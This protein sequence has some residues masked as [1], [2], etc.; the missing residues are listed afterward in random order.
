MNATRRQFLSAAVG[1]SAIVSLSPV[2]PNFLLQAAA[3]EGSSKGNTVLV[4][5]QLSGGNDGLNT[6]VPY[7]DDAYY[8]NRFTLAI[9]K[10]A[11]RKI[12]DHVG[13]HPSMSGF[14]DLLEAGSLS[15][16]QGVGYPNPNRSHFE[17]MDLWHTAHRQADRRQV[18]WL[19]NSLDKFAN[20]GRDVPAMHFGS[21]KQPLAL[22]AEKVRVPSIRSLKR[23]RLEGSKDVQLFQTIKTV[24]EADRSSQDDLLGFIQRSTVAAISTS[25]RVEQALGN[26]KSDVEYP[27]TRLAQKLKTVA[28]LIDA[29]MS[30]RVYYLTLGGFDTHANQAQAH[31]G[32]LN[33]LSGAIRSFVQDVDAHGHGE[34]VMVMTFSEFG[35]R[36]KENASR[37]TDHGAASQMFLAGNKVKPGLV[38]KHPSLTDLEDGDPKFHTDYRQVYATV[39]EDWLGWK[40]EA[41]LGK[42]FAKLPVIA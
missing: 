25:Q 24:T 20:L 42:R 12:D 35:R 27:G 21:E 13:L 32:L 36:L 34:R 30:T 10:N 2:V 31:A 15:I 16:I 18:G 28:Q 11:V 8:K 26:Y 22:A 37:G 19:G 5:V 1:S 14:S 3:R 29:G 23:F 40:S 33:E 7:G 4:V 38:G 9:G 17:S 39:L 6:V 41:V